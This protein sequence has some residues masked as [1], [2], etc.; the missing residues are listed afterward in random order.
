MR[1]NKQGTALSEPDF[2]HK[3]QLLEVTDEV[4][5]EL[6]GLEKVEILNP[7]R[8][9]YGDFKEYESTLLFNG[10]PLRFL[11]AD[12]TLYFRDT[13]EEIGGMAEYAYLVP[14]DGEN[15]VLRTTD[16]LATAIGV[17]EK[18]R[19][20]FLAEADR[21]CRGHVSRLQKLLDA[22]TRE[23]FEKIR[24]DA[25]RFI[26]VGQKGYEIALVQM[27]DAIGA[28]Q[29]IENLKIK[30]EKT[31]RKILSNEN[32]ESVI[33]AVIEN[34]K[35]EPAEKSPVVRVK[36]SKE[37]ELLYDAETEI[38][39][40]SALEILAHKEFEKEIAR[41]EAEESTETADKEEIGEIEDTQ[42][43]IKDETQEIQEN[44][45][46]EKKEESIINGVE[47]KREKKHAKSN[48]KGITELER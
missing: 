31:A 47:I 13:V 22:E 25:K 15:G 10:R 3:F 6:L 45:L 14:L 28:G 18:R 11:S 19:K 1:D 16:W 12:K 32:D 9:P 44:H 4:K 48:R 30:I 37:I 27:L 20:K 36:S 35:P 42:A 38:P 33:R 2:I 34:R 17:R 41:T 7:D 24:H 43:L 26:R 39:E 8:L 5:S 23:R 21:V 29:Y 40:D 46:P